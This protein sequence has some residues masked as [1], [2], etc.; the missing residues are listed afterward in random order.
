MKYS[1]R[2]LCAVLAVLMLMQAGALATSATVNS[3]SARIYS[4]DSTSSS[5][6]PL[7]KGMSVSVKDVSGSWARVSVKGVTGYVPVKYLKS[8]SRYKAYTNKSTYV[9]RSASSS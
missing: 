6:A 7:E 8:S 9:Y 2:I 3:S 1:M 4:S 5:S